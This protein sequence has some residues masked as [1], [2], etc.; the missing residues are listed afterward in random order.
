MIGTAEV[1]QTGLRIVKI[2]CL[3]RRLCGHCG[4]KIGGRGGGEGSEEWNCHSDR[5]YD[6]DISGNAHSTGRRTIIT[7]ADIPSDDDIS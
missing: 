6:L 1:A 3:E 7:L 2:D 5:R 4:K